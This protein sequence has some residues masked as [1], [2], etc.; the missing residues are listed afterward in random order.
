MRCFRVQRYLE[1]TFFFF[2]DWYS[3]L[4]YWNNLKPTSADPVAREKFYEYT[5]GVY[6]LMCFHDLILHLIFFFLKQELSIVFLLKRC[7]HE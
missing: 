3:G 2:F 4:N 6:N 5:K 1:G 7:S